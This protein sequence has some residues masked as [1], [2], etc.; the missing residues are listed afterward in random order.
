MMATTAMTVLRGSVG[1]NS[2][3]AMY[4]VTGE[5]RVTVAAFVAVMATTLKR[6]NGSCKDIGSGC[7]SGN[8]KGKG[9]GD[10]NGNSDSNGDGN[11]DGVG[12]GDGGGDSDSDWDGVGNGDGNSDGI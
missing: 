4:A 12:D 5:V 1:N 6:D 11:G 2:S 8:S 10:G 9:E 7:G 3:R